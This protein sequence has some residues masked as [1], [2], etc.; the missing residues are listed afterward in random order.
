MVLLAR[1]IAPLDRKLT[2]IEGY[3][4]YKVFLSFGL[5]IAILITLKFKIEIL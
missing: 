4:M 2:T 1:A 5:S 3:G